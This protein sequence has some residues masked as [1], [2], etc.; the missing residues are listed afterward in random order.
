MDSIK[1]KL[2][3]L[4][5]VISGPII[6]QFV[7]SIPRDPTME[8]IY[9]VDDQLK[10]YQSEM[11]YGNLS[12][13]TVAL[14]WLGWNLFFVMIPFDRYIGR[15]TVFGY[16][17]IYI[18]N[19][20]AL[21]I[22]NFLFFL[23]MHSFKPGLS[24]YLYLNYPYLV[25]TLNVFGL[26]MSF[27]MLLRGEAHKGKLEISEKLKPTSYI[28][29]F[30]RGIELHPRLWDFDIKQFLTRFGYMTWQMLLL[31]FLT[32]QY[33]QHGFDAGIIGHVAVQFYYLLL[34]FKREREHLISLDM[35]Y[36]RVGFN[37][38]WVYGTWVPIIHSYSAYYLVSHRTHLS[39]PQS[40]LFMIIGIIAANYKF[41]IDDEKYKF[42]E[43]DGV[44]CKIW[45]KNANYVEVQ[46]NSIEG[47]KPSRL[48][49]SGY[50]GIARHLNY[51]F[52][53]VCGLTWT[54][55]SYKVGSYLALLYPM[56]LF[57]LLIQRTYR[58]ETKCKDKYGEFWHKYCN[59]VKYRMVPY[60]F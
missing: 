14:L 26:V 60:L 22:M 27:A 59:I 19:G 11:T 53:L 33:H 12:T 3:P 28:Y 31:C 52:E 30:L 23:I 10:G 29:S 43:T 9:P 5:V 8:G 51:T 47:P 42:R 18:H 4:L 57:V 40:L 55:F 1:Y 44:N 58:D 16:S 34:F 7:A 41:K 17:P 35:T 50:W 36:S 56:Y 13:W 45:G 39:I 54:L 15:T 49:I 38:C 25:G 21:Y 46:Y 37:I 32:A 6:T 48:L 20:M 2:L 24:L